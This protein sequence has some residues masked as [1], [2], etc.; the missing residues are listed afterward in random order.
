[1]FFTAL[2]FA[3]VP[4]PIIFQKS[5]CLESASMIHTSFIVVFFR[6]SS[7]ENTLSTLLQ[8]S[9]RSEDEKDSSSP[10][11]TRASSSDFRIGER[12][13]FFPPRL[14]SAILFGP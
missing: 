3:S 14:L 7:G 6:T 12:G 2:T 11:S 4:V 13:Y 8:F 5:A 9:S 1:M 10:C